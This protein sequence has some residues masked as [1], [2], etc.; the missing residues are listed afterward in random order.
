MSLGGKGLKCTLDASILGYKKG[1][2][3]EYGTKEGRMK[4]VNVIMEWT[5]M[6]FNV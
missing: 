3:R 6:V 1:I 2:G 4:N 5:K